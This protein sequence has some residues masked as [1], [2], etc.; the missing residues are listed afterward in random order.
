[1]TPQENPIGD[2]FGHPG[3]NKS[4]IK[5]TSDSPPTG[6]SQS[7]RIPALPV[8]KN[9]LK[10]KTYDEFRHLISQFV[11]GL[12]RF[13]LIVGSSG[14][15]KSQSVKRAVGNRSHLFLETHATAF[16]MYHALFEHR[17][18]PVIIDDLD[19][20][21][22]DPASVRI[23]K[24]LCNTDSIKQ[25]RW[26]SRHADILSGQIPAS[27]A[28]SSPVC[29]IA[30]EWKTKNANVEAIEDRAIVVHFVPSAVEI[31]AKVADWFDDAEVYGFVGEF[32]SFIPRHSMRHYKKGLEL[33]QASAE[34]WKERLLE[35]M[36]VDEHVRAIVP[37]ITSPDYASDAERIAAFEAAGHGSRATFYRWKKL[38]GMT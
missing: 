10:I 2:G 3:V 4:S 7:I 18:L 33:R 16:G 19:N 38:L 1:M 13:L 23:L 22:C 30:N 32:L 11:A 21:Y 17:D 27:F 28:T 34:T 29:L 24:C 15:S 25:L 12:F 8:L 6:R 9:A 26:P 20:I 31:H 37:L 36:G 5:G 14:L 35:I